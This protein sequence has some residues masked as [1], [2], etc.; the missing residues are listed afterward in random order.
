MIMFTTNHALTAQNVMQRVYAWMSAGLLV[1]AASAYGLLLSPNLFNAIF[2]SMWHFYAI[3]ALQI[4]LVIY[5]SAF[6]N[7][8]RYSTAASVFML[9]SFLLGIT[10][11]PIFVIYTASSIALTFL[12]TAGMFGTMALYGSITKT[13]LTQMGNIMIMALWGM[14]IAS[15]ANWYFKSSALEY[16]LAFLGVIIFTALTAYDVQKIKQLI[17]RVSYEGDHDMYRE[18]VSKVALLGA[19]TLYLDF[20]NLFLHLLQFMGRKRD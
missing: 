18:M 12:C 13:D 6:I 4:G 15:F 3:A 20:V 14:I 16:A 2:S 19:L 8:M 10:L 7:E 5:V 9:Y 1:T 11:S 17:Y